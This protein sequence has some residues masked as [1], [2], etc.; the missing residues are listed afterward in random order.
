[1]KSEHV[2]AKIKLMPKKKLSKIIISSVGI[3]IVICVA[4]FF[5]V[6]RSAKS[7]SGTTE[8]TAVA[9]TSDL[10]TTI[11]GSGPIV[12]LNKMDISAKTSG[13]ITKLFYKQGEKVKAGALL[14]TIDPT[15]ALTNV[16]NAQNNLSQT[17]LTQNAN[18]SDQKSLNTVAPISGQIT[19]LAVNEGD[20]VQRNG[21]LFTVTDTRYMKLTVP[22]NGNDIK[23][24]KIGTIVDINLQNVMQS[25]KGKV[26]YVNNAAYSTAGG[27]ALYNV[28]ISLNNPGSLGEDLKASVDINEKGGVISSADVGSL[29]YANKIIVRSQ[30]GGTVQKINSKLYERVTRG[31]VVMKLIN[32][33]VTTAIQTTALKIEGLKQQLANAKTQLGYCNIISP[34]AGTVTEVLFKEGETLSQGNVLTSVTD[35]SHMIFQVPVDELDIAKVQVGQKV[36]VSLDA[37]T[38]T[39]TLPLTGK[40]TVVAVEGTSTGGVTAYNVTVEITGVTDPRTLFSAAGRTGNGNFTRRAGGTNFGQGT[41]S[42]GGTKTA[43]GTGSARTGGFTRGQG[44]GNG[45]FTGMSGGMGSRFNTTNL[46]S[47]LK[48]GMNANASILITENKGVLAVPLEAISRVNG[49]NY[50]MVKSDAAKVAALKKSGKYIDVFNTTTKSTSNSGVNTG[51]NS[52]SQAGNSISS[53]RNVLKQ[54]EAYY[55]NTIPTAVEVGV[56]NSTSIQITSGLKAGD[57]VLLPPVVAGTSSSSGNSRS[58]AS[59]IG[60]MLGGGGGNFSGGNQNRNSG[61]GGA[62]TRSTKT[63]GGN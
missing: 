63:G 38:E 44:G 26:T 62:S 25:I 27:G 10:S 49:T 6:S 39:S 22:F 31:N 1:M 29:T 17:E 9:Q 3:L 50:V 24:I 54:N 34:I 55:A 33:D 11:T 4:Y 12:S 36:D 37:L 40:V 20:I 57:V 35:T 56:N 46:L 8:Q 60:G 21:V 14:A 16:Q 32:T 42:G 61:Y 15:A 47:S 51:G 59:G 2:L 23:K 43:S 58:G 48:D 18:L 7:A 5:V 53:S 41:A 19:N 45:T 28:E 52:N 13:T 30:A